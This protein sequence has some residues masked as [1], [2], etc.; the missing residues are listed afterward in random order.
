L[1]ISPTL[2]SNWNEFGWCVSRFCGILRL[3]ARI[4]AEMAANPL[5]SPRLTLGEPSSD[6][7]CEEELQRIVRYAGK[8]RCPDLLPQS[9]AINAFQIEIPQP[10]HVPAVHGVL[11]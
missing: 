6:L 9:V 3:R 1:D 10:R 11:Y 5:S 7:L 8:T 2:L 4:F